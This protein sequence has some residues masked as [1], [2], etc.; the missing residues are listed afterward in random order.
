M[1][2]KIEVYKFGGVAVGSADAI[3]AAAAHVQ[4]VAPNVAVVVSAMNGVTDLLLGAAHAAMRGDRVAYFTAS[5]Q[6]ELRHT[7]IVNALI[8]H[9]PRAEAL[10]AMIQDSTH[11]MRAMCDSI[12]VL[13]ELTTRAQDTLIARGE[14]VLSR[15]FSVYL[16]ELG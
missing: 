6:Y 2:S 7:E 11:E 10:R 4:G 3:R 9:R 1:P 15:I 14:R 13:G 5:K 12:A 16:E 8:T